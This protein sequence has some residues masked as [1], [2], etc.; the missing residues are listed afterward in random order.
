MG[1]CWGWF[2]LTFF[3]FSSSESSK[4]SHIDIVLGENG[5]E[6]L[7]VARAAVDGTLGRVGVGGGLDNLASTISMSA[8][9]E[10]AEL[11][12]GRRVDEGCEEEGVSSDSVDTPGAK[13]ER[14][15]ELPIGFSVRA[16]D[17]T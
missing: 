15:F 13:G 1:I 5:T 14:R 3:V 10:D 8:S 9:S 12:R 2:F 16:L 4:V 6:A 11:I 17:E 7:G